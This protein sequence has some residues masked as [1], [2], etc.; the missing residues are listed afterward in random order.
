MKTQYIIAPLFIHSQWFFIE[1]FGHTSRSLPG[2]EF[3]GL[4]ANKTKS[5]KE[6]FLFL[7][8]Q[9]GH[10][11]PPRRYVIGAEGLE[12]LWIHS[13]NKKMTRDIY[14]QLE[15][16]LYFMFCCLADL[17]AMKNLE[18]CYCLGKISLQGTIQDIENISFSHSQ[19]KEI[20]D[21]WSEDQ[22]RPQIWLVPNKMIQRLDIRSE[23]LYREK[24]QDGLTLLKAYIDLERI[25]PCSLTKSTTFLQVASS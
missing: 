19:K 5:F 15:L 24:N 25:L 7:L 23:T 2:I 14:E 21:D 11:I 18:G 1:V 17:V 12:E 13:K 6:K 22:S 9:A 10:R 4:P 16:P 8:K 3:V 20:S